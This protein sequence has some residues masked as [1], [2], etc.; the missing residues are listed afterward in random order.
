VRTESVWGGCQ[1]GTAWRPDSLAPWL[2]AT[3]LFPRSQL[4][5]LER[6][7]R[8]ASPAPLLLTETHF[9]VAFFYF[10]QKKGPA[11]PN[12]GHEPRALRY[13]L[14]GQ[15]WMGRKGACN[16]PLSSGQRIKIH[17]AVA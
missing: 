11:R 15:A 16:V 4:V 1:G 7:D 5:K 3:T 13:N 9:L 12:R 10:F 2:V 8:T 6:L 17:A 14:M